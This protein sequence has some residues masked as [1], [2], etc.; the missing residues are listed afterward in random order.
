[1][2]CE[3][4]ARARCVD[5]AAF[6]EHAADGAEWEECDDEILRMDRVAASGMRG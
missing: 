4:S 2:D 6:D 1:M 3:E 5:V